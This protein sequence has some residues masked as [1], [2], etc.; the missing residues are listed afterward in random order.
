MRVNTK[1]FFI[2]IIVLN[3]KYSE[4][5]KTTEENSIDRMLWC[6]KVVFNG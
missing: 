5:F 6:A 1:K 3:N 4:L 2:L